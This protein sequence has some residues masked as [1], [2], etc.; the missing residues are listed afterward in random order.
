MFMNNYP[1]VGVGTLIIKES[2]LLLLKRL[3]VHGAGTWST[4]GGHLDFGETPAACA[5]REVKEETG[6]DI[7][8]VR[9]IGITND[10]FEAE[11]L[12]YITLWMAGDYLSGE[13]EINAPGE[14]SEVR[15]F[16]IT[17]IPKNLF[18]PLKNLLTGKGFT[19]EDE[20]DLFTTHI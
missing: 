3:N 1:R 17:E 10:I 8:N 15:W 16:A 18:L 9:F 4:P 19:L 2:Q 7:A 5:I 12:H 13:P 14:M 6:V 20:F 11:G